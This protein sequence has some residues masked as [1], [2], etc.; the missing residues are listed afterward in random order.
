MDGPEVHAAHAPHTGHRW[1]DFAIGG[2][3]L[4]TSLV[5]LYVAVE[6]GHT[7]EKLVAANSWPNLYASG[8]VLEAP[9]GGVVFEVQIGNNGIGPARLVTLEVFDGDKPI[10]DAGDLARAIRAAGD[11]KALNARLAGATAV[12]EVVAPGQKLSLIGFETPE[13]ERWGLPMIKLANR[14]GTRICYCSVFDECFTADSR[15]RGKPAARVE[16]CPVPPHPFDDRVGDLLV[17]KASAP[18]GRL[19]TEAPTEPSLKK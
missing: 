10:K 5:S 15:Q 7:M 17:A 18:G 13:T 2:A 16:A 19:V 6:H 9:K 1:W 12:G 14:L 3:A 11:G 4:V 8:N